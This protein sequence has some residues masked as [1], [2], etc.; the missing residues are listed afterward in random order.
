VFV[1]RAVEAAWPKPSEA[2]GLVDVCVCTYRRPM[3]RECL[4]AI[5]A[6]DVA[7]PFRLIVADN[8]EE[9]QARELVESI[10]A[11]PHEVVYVHAP[12]HNISIA[13]NACLDAAKGEWVAF[14][15]DDET[16]VA[17]WLAA[18][19]AEA[20]RGKWDAV[21]GPVNAVYPKGAPGWMKAGGF[22]STR[23]VWVKGEILTGYTGNVLIRRA[24]IERTHIR[25]RE[26]FGRTG[27]EDLDFFYRLRDW[28]A[29]IG[30]APDA[31]AYERVEEPRAS[32]K[33]L[34]RRNFRAGQS[35]GSR[36]L[37]SGR[38]AKSL[39]AAGAKAAVCG[40]GAVLTAPL[41]R[42]RNRF[43]TRA[44]MHAGVVARLAGRTEIETY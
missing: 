1:Q 30:F 41:P 3:L 16:P 34:M 8:A 17:G 6:Q 20:K 9:P 23:P 12:A 15:D 38:R 4:E 29:R 25:F 26:E 32:L 40:V 39:P 14:I 43:L 28:G 24:V 10:A 27:G 37:A 31:V 36:L 44:A 42:A 5:L 35:H 19:L 33:W 18:L 21:L 11:G 7:A 22:H 2:K 13:R